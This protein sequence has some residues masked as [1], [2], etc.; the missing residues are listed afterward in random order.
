[1]RL[2]DADKLIEGRVDNDPVVISVKCEPTAYDVDAVVEQINEVSRYGC[3]SGQIVDI[4]RA[5]G[6]HE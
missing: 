5:G 6:K 2:I 1:M 4:V 3:T